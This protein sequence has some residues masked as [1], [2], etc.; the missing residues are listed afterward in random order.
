MIHQLPLELLEASRNG[1]A[2]NILADPPTAPIAVWAVRR[3]LAGMHPI[4]VATAAGVSIRTAYRWRA[5]IEHIEEI[6]VAGF[7]ATFVVRHDRPPMQLTVW[8]RTA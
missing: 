6:A 5:E 1:L 3:M 7:R 8:R 2:R 4:S